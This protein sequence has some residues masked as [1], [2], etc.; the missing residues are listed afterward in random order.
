MVSEIASTR[1]VFDKMFSYERKAR[2]CHV[3]RLLHVALHPRACAVINQQ[4]SSIVLFAFVT[5]NKLSSI[6]SMFVN[7]GY[8]EHFVPSVGRCRLLRLLCSDTKSLPHISVSPTLVHYHRDLKSRFVG[9][10]KTH[11]LP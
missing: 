2:L 7:V 4:T 8:P 11:P 9:M 3:G 10:L 1:W 6:K 5:D